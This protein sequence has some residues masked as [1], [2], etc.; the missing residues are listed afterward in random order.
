MRFIVDSEAHS[1]VKQRNV[2]LGILAETLFYKFKISRIEAEVGEGTI[3]RRK[4]LRCQSVPVSSFRGAS[5]SRECYFIRF[6]ENSLKT[7]R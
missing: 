5:A 1:F 4:N 7:I 3:T 2:K 6:A